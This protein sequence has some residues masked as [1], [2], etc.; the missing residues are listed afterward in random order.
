MPTE[1]FMI[2][3][4]VLE[5]LEYKKLLVHTNTAKEEGTKRERGRECSRRPSGLLAR[6]LARPLGG[7][8]WWMLLSPPPPP[9]TFNDVIPFCRNQG[10]LP[11]SLPP[12]LSAGLPGLERLANSRLGQEASLAQ[13]VCR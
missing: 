2:K 8:A 13:D 6:S 3:S 5:P 10:R 4:V 9:L 11:P 1:G 7:C 12:S